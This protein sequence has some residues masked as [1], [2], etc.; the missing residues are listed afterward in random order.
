MTYRFN[1]ENYGFVHV[2]KVKELDGILGSTTYVK[3]IAGE[4]NN[5]M[6]YI[7]IRPM[8]MRG[9]DRY[10]IYS[11]A[12]DFRRPEDGD[13]IRVRTVYLGLISNEAFAEDLLR[14]LLGTTTNDSVNTIGQ[15]RLC[16]CRD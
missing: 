3:Y 10:E 1:P 8:A 14:H 5:V 7:A 16:E 4:R 2:S 12:F 9:D 6:W 13:N 15:E 11:G